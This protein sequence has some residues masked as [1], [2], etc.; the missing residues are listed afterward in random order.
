M[1]AH[2][3]AQMLSPRFGRVQRKGP[4][5]SIAHLSS[6]TKAYTPSLALA[7]GRRFAHTDPAL[8]ANLGIHR[9]D[10]PGPASEFLSTSA[11]PQRT[12]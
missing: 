1:N 8:A 9:S 4:D 3:A 6:P 11:A 2:P 7:G 5:S 10:D 12:G